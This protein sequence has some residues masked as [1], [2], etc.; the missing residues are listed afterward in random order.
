MATII[1]DLAAIF[2]CLIGLDD[3]VT[4]MSLFSYG[5]IEAYLFIIKS[6]NA[7]II[8]ARSTITQALK[9]KKN[10]LCRDSFTFYLSTCC[11]Q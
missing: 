11:T 8:T 1:G 3:I 4:G 6:L 7:R 5:R 9:K 2:G 10:C